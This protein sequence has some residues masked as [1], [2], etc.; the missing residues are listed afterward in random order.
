MAKPV[1]QQKIEEKLAAKPL[2]FVAV[3]VAKGTP[4]RDIPEPII[5]HVAC[6]DASEKAGK[7]VTLRLVVNYGC[8]NTCAKCGV[9]I[10]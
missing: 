10:R 5:K 7:A 1:W 4:I 8:F 3:K 6:L 2:C 9:T